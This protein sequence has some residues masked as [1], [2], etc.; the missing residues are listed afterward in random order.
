MITVN[1]AD[2]EKLMYMKELERRYV[3]LLS[4]HE[5]LENAHEDLKIENEE[6]NQK[7]N[8]LEAKF[9]NL[10]LKYQ[11]AIADIHDSNKYISFLEEEI[12][13]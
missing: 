11:Y 7:M 6:L 9:S 5:E 4:I 10:E 8:K 12:E 1:K 2:Y 13:K 3:E